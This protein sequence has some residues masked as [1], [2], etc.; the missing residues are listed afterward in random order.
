MFKP[1]PEIEVMENKAE[2][3]TKPH[4]VSVVGFSGSGKTTLVE[5]LIAELS[6]RGLKIGS[7]K[8]H[9]HRSSV[10]KPGKDSWRHRQAGASAT[11]VSSPSQVGL[12]KDVDHDHT[13]DELAPMLDFVDF[14]VAEGFKRGPQA[15]VEI[16]RPGACENTAPICLEDPA[17]LAVVTD[18]PLDIDVPLFGLNDI[19]GLADFLL[20]RFEVAKAGRKSLR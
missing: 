2:R 7:I 15:K 5:K 3:K 13:I 16:F 4:L 8:H 20:A 6:S 9:A 10:D 17:L 18:A 14:I 12:F 19:S 11:I 1:E